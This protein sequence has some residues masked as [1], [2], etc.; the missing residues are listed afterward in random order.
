MHFYKVLEYGPFSRCKLKFLGCAPEKISVKYRFFLVKSGVFSLFSERR[1]FFF[2]SFILEY[3][4][5]FFVNVLTKFIK[6]YA[7]K[8]LHTS[9]FEL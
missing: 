9:D 7:R 2:L 1:Q 3:Y 5:I 8:R 6:G 4:N